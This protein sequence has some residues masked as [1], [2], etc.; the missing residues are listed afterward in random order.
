MKETRDTHVTED[1]EE[2]PPLA[3]FIPTLHKA[4][5]LAVAKGTGKDALFVFA[6]MVK[7]FEVTTS[8]TLNP[9][10]LQ[11]AFSLWW[12]YAKPHLPADADSDEYRFFFEVT[13]AK[14]RAPWGANPLEEA[15]KRAAASTNVPH[16][17]RYQSPKIRWLVALCYH[18]QVLAG[19]APFFLSLRDAARL[20]ALTNLNQASAFIAGLV[21]DGVLTPVE[22]G[23]PGGKRASRYRF[24]LPPGS[25]CDFKLQP[26]PPSHQ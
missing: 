11:N 24:N 7:A 1:S 3:A 16:A 13:Y 17:E 23:R 4:V 18:L 25:S 12:T 2:A 6:R 19:E 14:V 26:K 15:A 22:K 10:E 21:R 5:E 9:T 20:C 8:V